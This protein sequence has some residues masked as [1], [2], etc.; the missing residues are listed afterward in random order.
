MLRPRRSGA[1][2]DSR[3][4]AAGGSGETDGR[5]GG[6]QKRQETSQGAGWGPAGDQ[7]GAEECDIVV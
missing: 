5:E 3:G 4:T 6:V 1:V 7:G 2:S